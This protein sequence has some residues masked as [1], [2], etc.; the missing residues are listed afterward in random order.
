MLRRTCC[1]TF[2][3]QQMLRGTFSIQQMHHGTCCRI[4]SLQQLLFNMLQIW[5]NRNGASKLTFSEILNSLSPYC[6]ISRGRSFIHYIKHAIMEAFL[7]EICLEPKQFTFS[8]FNFARKRLP[9][10]LLIEMSCQLK[11]FRL[12]CITNSKLW[13]CGNVIIHTFSVLV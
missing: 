12:L 2:S 3:I 6:D 9:R 8:T 1:R 7:A 4:F 10:W 11:N 5:G 13:H